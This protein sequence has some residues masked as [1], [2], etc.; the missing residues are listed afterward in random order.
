ML[1]IEMFREEPEKI[2]ESEKRRDKDPERVDRVRELD[3][4]WRSTRQELDEL[5]HRKNELTDRIQELKQEGEDASD[6]IKEAEE[7]DN[8][9][10]EL[11]DKEEELLEERDE[12]RF[13]VGNIMHESVPKGE[14]E[15]DNVPIKHWEP[16]E[17]KKEDAELGADVMEELDLIE[18]EKAVEVAGDRAYYL[19]NDLLDLN[20]ALIRYGL[21]RMREKGYTP[22]QTPYILK[23]GPMEAAAELEDFHDQLYKLDRHEKYL[24]ATSEQTL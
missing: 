4:E 21:D 7:L 15:D 12:V 6:E 19:K 1:D 13:K 11:E 16:G 2:K 5:R 14:D 10:E 18:N 23:E 20:L 17:G 3:Q 9:M 22:M 8:K 24:I